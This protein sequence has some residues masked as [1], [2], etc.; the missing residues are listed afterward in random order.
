MSRISAVLSVLFA[1]LATPALAQ[2]GSRE[3][4]IRRTAPYSEMR[5]QIAGLTLRDYNE[6]VRELA[7]K[8]ARDEMLVPG[9]PNLPPPPTASEVS[10]L[11]R[12]RPSVPSTGTSYDWRSGNSYRWRKN[13]DGSTNVNGSNPATGS[14]WRTQIKPDGSMRG[15]D[16]D[17]NPW[18]YNP[19]TKTYMNYGTGQI[20]TG[21]GYAR[22][23][24]Q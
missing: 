11:P 6:A 14:T 13:Y 12:Y 22:V 9:M 17:F 8:E 16:S 1:L 24:T 20:C 15:T 5:R 10:P 3:A 2:Y 7:R 23:C 18:T 19:R 4:E 21:E